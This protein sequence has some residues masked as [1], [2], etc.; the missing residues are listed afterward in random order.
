[1]RGESQHSA[2][3][4]DSVALERLYALVPATEEEDLLEE[5]TRNR[6]RLEWE[7][8][9]RHG[10]CLSCWYLAD[11]PGEECCA[12]PVSDGAVVP[13]TEEETGLTT[14]QAVALVAQQLGAVVVRT[15]LWG[16]FAPRAERCDAPGDVP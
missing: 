10:R 16:F 14:A 13:E 4:D 11:G 5:V 15:E 8:L 12:V 6:V 9:L 1:M 3:V 2:S 7:R